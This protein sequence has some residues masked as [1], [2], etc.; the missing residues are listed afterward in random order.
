MRVKAWVARTCTNYIHHCACSVALRMGGSLYMPHGVQ[1]RCVAE[2]G[3]TIS[4]SAQCM[5][6]F[7]GSP[8]GAP[9]HA[10]KFSRDVTNPF[11]DNHLAPQGISSVNIHGGHA[12]NK[13]SKRS[14]TALCRNHP[15]NM[16]D[17]LC[18]RDFARVYLRFLSSLCYAYFYPRFIPETLC[19]VILNRQHIDWNC[20]DCC[21]M[22]DNC[23]N[24][25]DNTLIEKKI[26]YDYA[27]KIT[28]RINKKLKCW[29]Y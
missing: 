28:Q 27:L 24:Y 4:R 8:R 17:G 12:H 13:V 11:A 6:H 7:D 22:S 2:K 23:M 16:G 5:C 20:I 18:V 25:I 29:Q 3:H 21:F 14:R 1:Q 15:N 19:I 9:Q 10:S 26:F